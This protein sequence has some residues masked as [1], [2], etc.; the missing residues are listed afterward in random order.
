M[1][2]DQKIAL[3]S[4]VIAFVGLIFV[5]LQLRDS[6]RQRRSDSLVKILDIN[7]ELIAL[8]FAHPTL[9][10]ILAGK[11]NTDPLWTQ[12]YLQLWLNQFSLVHSYLE[13]SMLGGEV[14]D[15]LL[16]DISEFML[17]DNVRKHWHTFGHLYPAS[18]QAYINGILKKD[19]PPQK[20]AHPG[21]SRRHHDAKT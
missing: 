18:F 20:A 11:D 21:E 7:R 17:N 9:F 5:A 1:T 4:S 14:R 6:T 2:L 3:L 10:A 15:N 8:G 16:R 12:R 13:H 19:E